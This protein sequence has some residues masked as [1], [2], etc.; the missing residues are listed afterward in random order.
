LHILYELDGVP[1][2]PINLEGAREFIEELPPDDAI[3]FIEYMQKGV[4]S[5]ND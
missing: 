4:N 2:G 5:K 3:E 1:Y